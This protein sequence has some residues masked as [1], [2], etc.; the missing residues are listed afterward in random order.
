M[1]AKERKAIAEK[2]AT[3]D[4]IFLLQIKRLAIPEASF[5]HDLY[6]ESDYFDEGGV[7]L[8]PDSHTDYLEAD[9]SEEPSEEFWRNCKT[10]DKDGLVEQGLAVYYWDADS[11]WMTR[12][13]AE[14]EAEGRS[15]HY[16]VKGKDWRV[17]CMCAEGEL[18]Q[19]LIG[20]VAKG[21][22]YLPR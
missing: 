21:T 20:G 15:Y 19:L 6:V 10:L 5:E 1:L 17:Y 16:G 9:F 3:R 8:T 13:E 2:E 14:R 11:V 18:A 7:F 12:E 4:P 22:N